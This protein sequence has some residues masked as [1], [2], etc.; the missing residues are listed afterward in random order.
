MGVALLCGLVNGYAI[1]RFKLSPFVVTLIMLSVARSQALILSNNKMI[2][3]FGPD[4]KLFGAL[5]GGS[6]F[7]IPSVVVAMAMHRR[8][9]HARYGQHQ[10]GPVCLRHRRQR[11]SGAADRRFQSFRS[12]SPSMSSAAS[13]RDSPPF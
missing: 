10:L 2:Y 1:A 13:R 8:S 5:G 6:L 11:T 4:E 3:Q 9:P 12:R 7:G